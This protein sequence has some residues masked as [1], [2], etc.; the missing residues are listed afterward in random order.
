MDENPQ[1]SSYFKQTKQNQWILRNYQENLR[2]LRNSTKQNQWILRNYQENLLGGPQ[3][4]QGIPNRGECRQLYPDARSSLVGLLICV[5]TM[6]QEIIPIFLFIQVPWTQSKFLWFTGSHKKGAWRDE[7]N[8]MMILIT[9]NDN[10]ITI[11]PPR[12]PKNNKTPS[13]QFHSIKILS[14]RNSKLHKTF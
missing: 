1:E 13:P 10:Q 8:L 4:I 7:E 12:P 11:K 6:S 5:L 3:R 14:G 2:I 9:L